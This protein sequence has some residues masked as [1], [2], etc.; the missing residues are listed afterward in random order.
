MLVLLQRTEAVWAN[1]EGKGSS[2]LGNFVLDWTNSNQPHE[3]TESATTEQFHFNNH[4]L[5]MKSELATLWPAETTRTFMVHGLVLPDPTFLEQVKRLELEQVK[6]TNRLGTSD[7]RYTAP[8][9]TQR[10]QQSSHGHLFCVTQE[11]D[12]T[13]CHVQRNQL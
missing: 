1:S 8:S 10:D 13:Q 4:R 2:D 12:H 3:H 7:L 6:S 5:Q 11:S 9:G